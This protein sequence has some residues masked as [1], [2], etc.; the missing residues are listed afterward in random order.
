MKRPQ[1]LPCLLSGI[2]LLLSA[3]TKPEGEDLNSIAAELCRYIP[4]HELLESSKDYMTEDFY[5]LLDTMFHLPE[6]EAMDHE[7][8]HYFVTGNGGTIADFEVDS[9]VLTDASHALAHITVRQMWEDSTYAEGEDAVEKHLM[10]MQKEGGRWRIADFDGHKQDCVRHIAIWRREEAMRQAIADYLVADIASHYVPGQVSVPVLMLV[11]T[12]DDGADS[13]RIWGDFWVFNYDIA[14]DTLKTVSGGNHSGCM[15]LAK[16][17]GGQ[18]RVARFEQTD[19]GAAFAPSARRI[20]GPHYDIYQSIH[21]NEDIREAV[22]RE[23]LQQYVLQHGLRVKYYQD[24][25]WDAVA[26]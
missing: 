3:C 19:D 15:T 11:E 13:L 12:E 21:S 2:M 1:L 20:F 14:G 7:W 9:V 23:Q 25:G 24:F 6:H 26:L 8:L 16:G 17:D 5:A 22:R 18:L 4:D 10:S